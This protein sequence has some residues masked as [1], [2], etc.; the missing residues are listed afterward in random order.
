M[1]NTTL[2]FKTCEIQDVH[3]HS[4]H[5]DQ[6]DLIKAAQHCITQRFTAGKELSS[7]DAAKDHIQILIGQY[8]HEVFYALWLDNKHRIIDH[9]ELF[10]GTIDASVVYPR[11]VAKSALKC[12]AAAAIF[13]HNHPSGSTEPSQADIKITCRLKEAL[14]LVDIRILDH[15]IV[16]SDVTSMAELGLL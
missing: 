3:G 6:D 15:L 13:A 1:N 11:E 2:N 8:E 5:I 14:A 7:A 9:G 4:Y 16:G 12:N 10:R